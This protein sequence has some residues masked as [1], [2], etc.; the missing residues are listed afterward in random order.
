MG[1]TSGSPHSVHDSESYE[2]ESPMRKELPL[3]MSVDGY[4]VVLGIPET[5]TQ[6]E[7][8][9][10]YRRLIRQIHPD[11]FPNCSP[12]W[13]SATEKKSR[14][15]I[16]AYYVLSDS[17]QRSSYDQQLARHRQQHAPA[18]PPPQQRAATTFPPRLL[19]SASKSATSAPNRSSRTTGHVPRTPN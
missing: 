5:A 3:D 12:Y 16:E 15:V 10:A 6:D 13:K 8:K 17:A 11:R 14:E 1:K 19:H 4:Y 7:I 9:R 18:P 2:R